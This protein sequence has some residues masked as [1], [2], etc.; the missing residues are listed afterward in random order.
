MSNARRTLK[1]KPGYFEDLEARLN[2]SGHG[3]SECALEPATEGAER[4]V[5]A[6]NCFAADMYE[7]LEREDG[8]LFFSPLSIST[9]LAMTHA[10]AAGETAHQMEEV[11]HL[12]SEPG[13]HAAFAEL[14]DQIPMQSP[15]TEMA[16][17]N[18]MWPHEDFEFHED[19]LQLIES[20]YQGNAQ[21]LDYASNPGGARDTINAWVEDRTQGKIKDLIAELN[22]L[23]RMVLT[24]ALYF[25]ASWLAPMG[26]LDLPFT[27]EDGKQVVVPTMTSLEAY[28]YTEIDGFK[29]VVVPN[30]AQPGEDDPFAA[31]ARGS[32]SSV[33]LLPTGDLSTDDLSP[34][35]L[36]KAQAWLDG[37]VGHLPY[38]DLQL[39]IFE[40]TVATDLKPILT[41]MG[42]TDMFD[43]VQSDFSNMTDHTDFH[44]MQA[45]HKAFVSADENGIEAAAATAIVGGIICFAAGTP[46]KTEDGYKAIEDI[47]VGDQVLSRSEYDVEG[48]IETKPVL[49]T[50]KNETEIVNL[51][52]GGQV[53]RTTSEH[54]FFVKNQ[55]WKP[56]CELKPG[57][58]L[59]ADLAS[60]VELQSVEA[61]G[62]IES[63]YNFRVADYHTYFVGKNEWGFSVWAHNC[64]CD[65]EHD[66]HAD[67]P[68]HF[69][70]RDDATSAI[71][72]MGRIEDPTQLQNSLPGAVGEPVDP[73]VLPGD[74]DG[75]NDVDFSD[76]LLLSKNYGQEEDAAFADGDFNGDGAV[77]F[78]D[79]LILQENFGQD[80]N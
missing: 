5:R 7:H 38:V 26:K 57:D 80:R 58:L 32:T 28:R 78:S 49:E 12:G 39:P 6:V 64:C 59:A 1:S 69:M 63:V 75:D 71:L 40:T 54:P 50:F 45:L 43:P 79:F 72:F 70:I 4:A 34:E 41:R 62:E 48:K 20:S 22:Q 8:N 60:W 14:L 19:Y 77:N 15:G 36:A 76:F 65:P 17:A 55:G 24:N 27:M 23:T 74:A 10:G 35:I 18:A 53:I 16:L 37:S 2:L 47:E 31:G 25:K 30:G 67:R 52:V 13:V 61:T 33:F 66:F 44:I 29:M 9:A 73:E 68:F 56:A 51:E 11:L 46:I 21:S 3:V 42:I